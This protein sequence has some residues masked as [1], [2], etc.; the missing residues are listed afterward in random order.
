MNE[1]IISQYT[2]K[3]I[4]QG[5]RKTFR[6]NITESMVNEFAKITGDYAP[7]HMNEEHAR[8][9]D[10]KHRICHGMLI[11]SFFSR[12]VGMHLPGEN[13]LLLS[14][15]G[16]HLLPCFLNQEIVVEGVVIAKSNATRIITIKAT[17]KDGFGK[18]L[19]DGLLKVLVMK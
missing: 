15:S 4:E 13:G 5:L 1:A 18:L 7:M 3:D 16:N 2:L 8:R 10:F 14:Y 17:I 12:L 11:G 6:V 19:V 9:T